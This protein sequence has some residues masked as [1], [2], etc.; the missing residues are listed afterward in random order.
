MFQFEK[1]MIK[2]NMDT[3]L[4]KATPKLYFLIS[5]NQ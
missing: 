3:L 5:Y 1:H 2:L 4:H